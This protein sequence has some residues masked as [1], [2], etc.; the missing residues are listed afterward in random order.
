MQKHKE[1]EKKEAE[2]IGIKDNYRGWLIKEKI[3]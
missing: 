3:R 1:G 2:M